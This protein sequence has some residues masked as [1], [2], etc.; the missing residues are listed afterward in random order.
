MSLGCQL[1]TPF[2]FGRSDTIEITGKYMCIC[3][4]DYNVD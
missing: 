4:K 2:V 3:I 1:T